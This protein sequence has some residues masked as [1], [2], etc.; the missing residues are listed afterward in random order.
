MISNDAIKTLQMVSDLET[1]LISVEF[2]V[3]FEKIEPESRYT[4]FYKEEEKM[5]NL[6]AISSLNPSLYAP[7]YKNKEFHIIKAGKVVFDN[8]SARYISSSEN[9][10]TDLNF[11]V[12]AGEKIGVVGRTGAGKTSLLKLF[13]RCLDPSKGRI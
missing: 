10:I 9:V 5:V 6:P 2:C 8:V 12:R 1:M 3:D 4:A 7:S 13:W 11:I